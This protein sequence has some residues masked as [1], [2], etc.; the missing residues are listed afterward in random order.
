MSLGDVR[1]DSEEEGDKSRSVSPD[2]Q[3]SASVARS[4]SRSKSNSASPK[5]SPYGM[6]HQLLFIPMLAP[7]N[8]TL[9]HHR[10]HHHQVDLFHHQ[11]ENGDDLDQALNLATEEAHQD[12][13]RNLVLQDLRRKM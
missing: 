3:R 13:V 9:E 6:D 5:S 1:S 2:S 7:K 12:H 8:L 11:M 4:R 10:D